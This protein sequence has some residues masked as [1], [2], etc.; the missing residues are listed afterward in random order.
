MEN[1]KSGKFC[2]CCF[3]ASRVE[4]KKCDCGYEFTP[5]PSHKRMRKAMAMQSL[6]AELMAE[7]DR[8][9]REKT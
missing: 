4:L 1:S 2:P 6:Q 3:K 8:I 9:N 5:P 7:V